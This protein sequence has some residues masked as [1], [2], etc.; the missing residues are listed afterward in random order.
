[1]QTPAWSHIMN[2]R[3]AWPRPSRFWL[4]V[5]LCALILSIGGASAGKFADRIV[6]VTD[7]KAPRSLPE[8]GPVSVRWNDP[9][10]FSELRGSHNRSEA[11]R[12]DWV[13]DIARY[14]RERAERAL[15]DDERLDITITDIR[16]AG[17]YEPWRG[18][19]F[20]DMRIMRE[21]YWPRIAIEIKRTRADGT[22]IAEGAQVLSDPAYLGSASAY[23]EGDPL[24]Y[25]KNMID[26]W[27]RRELGRHDA[28]AAPKP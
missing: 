18:L 4:A 24:R 28:N 25:E 22:V 6:R 3:S 5:L 26:R 12:G 16:R 19:E 14:L 17:N 15:P 1:M 8:E 21:L 20:R 10:T 7:P 13:A 27:V 23:G 2:A 11:E 9:A